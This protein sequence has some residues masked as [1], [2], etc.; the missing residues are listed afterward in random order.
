MSEFTNPTDN[1][2]DLDW[3]DNPT[4]RPEKP[5]EGGL[6]TL[7]NGDYDFEFVTAELTHAKGGKQDRIMEAKL[8]VNGGQVIKHAWWL[9]SQENMNALLADLCLLGFPANTWGQN[10]GNPLKE[11]LPAAIAQLPG[12]RFRASKTSSPKKKDGVPTGEFWHNLHIAGA[13]SGR[14]MPTPAAPPQVPAYSAP[15]EEAPF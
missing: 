15:R 4:L 5:F 10:T 13:V 3:Y 2:D 12:K 14:P 7:P 8:R 11:A 9:A 6:D 1:F